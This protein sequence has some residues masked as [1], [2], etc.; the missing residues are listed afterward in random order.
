[1]RDLLPIGRFARVARLSVKQLRHYDDIGLLHPAVVDRGSGYRYY[2]LDQATDALLIRQLRAVDLPLADIRRLLAE[3]D[4]VARK[5]LLAAH[6]GRVEDGLVRQ[7]EVLAFL[8]RLLDQE[9]MLMTYD[10]E[11]RAQDEQPFVAVRAHTTQAA[12]EQASARHFPALFGFLAQAAAAPAGP[13]FIRYLGDEFDPDD[14]EAEFG[15]PVARPVPGR[16]GIAAGTLPAGPV[17]VTVHLGPY[18]GI[19]LAYRALTA[20]I[21]EHGHETAGPVRESYL[22]GPPEETDPETYRTEI[23]W[24]IR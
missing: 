19:S 21:S 16:D 8:D 23:A 9:G 22:I 5:E 17:A 4:P 24:P 18:E 20:W 3:P 2:R 10:I 13:P 15:V 7:R 14:I 1:M 6:R 12:L 11:V